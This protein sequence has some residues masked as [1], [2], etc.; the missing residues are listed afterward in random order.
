[1]VLRC[2]YYRFFRFETCPLPTPIFAPR[3]HTAVIHGAH[4]P[5][6]D[7]LSGKERASEISDIVPA[8]MIAVHRPHSRVRQPL[9]R[10][11]A[12]PPAKEAKNSDAMAKILV[13]LSGSGREMPIAHVTA[14]S[15]S[16]VAA[17]T[18]KPRKE[19]IKRFFSL[20]SF[21]ETAFFIKINLL[22]F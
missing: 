11:V 19:H 16:A 7:V 3:M 13:Y 18:H 10:A 4:M 1:M 14:A 12:N 15:K 5:K 2:M 22:S 20:I 17:A 9:A 21:A 6:S 8:I